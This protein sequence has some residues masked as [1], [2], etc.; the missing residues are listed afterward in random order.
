MK[1]RLFG[2]KLT[3]GFVYGVQDFYT[4]FS[5]SHP[6]CI[7]KGKATLVV[8]ERE[9]FATGCLPVPIRLRAGHHPELAQSDKRFKSY[10]GV[11]GFIGSSQSG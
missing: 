10:N 4:V 8:L 5:Q 6:N 2:A 7:R 11:L 3:G 1:K 9:G